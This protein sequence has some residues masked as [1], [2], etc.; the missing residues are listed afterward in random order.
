VFLIRVSNYV[1]LLLL[2]IIPPIIG[3]GEGYCNEDYT[4]II[5]GYFRVKGNGNITIDVIPTPRFR[6]ASLYAITILDTTS[7]EYPVRNY[8]IYLDNGEVTKLI[9]PKEQLSEGWNDR[10]KTTHINNLN[11]LLFND[12]RYSEEDFIEI[13][14]FIVFTYFSFPYRPYFE[15]YG[16]VLFTKF[17]AIADEEPIVRITNGD[18]SVSLNSYAN[19]AGKRREYHWELVFSDSGELIDFGF[20][21]DIEP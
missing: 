15:A 9:P 17:E 5:E 13:T 21:V 7:L 8:L 3:V 2:L 19:F 12:G 11:C 4:E 16:T 14:E 6:T 20:D 10:S 1:K 18:V